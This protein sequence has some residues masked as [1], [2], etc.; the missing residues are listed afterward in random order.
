MAV[1]PLPSAARAAGTSGGAG[2]V[3]VVVTYRCAEDAVACLASLAAAAPDL[4]VVVVDNASG[5]GT[6][7]RV[8]AWIDASGAGDRVRLIALAENAGFGAGCNRG[9]DRALAERPGLDHVLL[10]NPDCVVG[11]GFLGPLL[12]TAARHPEAGVVGGKILTHD[13]ADVWFEHGEWRPWTLGSAHVPAP[14]AAEEDEV[15]FVTGALMLVDAGLL[16]EGLRF[17]ERFFLYCEDADLCREVVRRGRTLRVNRRSVVRHRGAGSQAGAAKVVGNM[18]ALQLRY[19]TRN[20]VLL[21]RKR[22]TAPQFA[23][24]CLVVWVV[25]PV[26]WML[27]FRT[28]GFLPA[29]FRALVEGF[30]A[31]TDSSP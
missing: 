17:D 20:K 26:S 27:R 6:P 22:L 3:A 25:R 10:V 15:G 31:G 24:F 5:D 16:R 1:T 21:A 8:A 30:G 11:P 23:A 19:I 2:N 13:G 28:V 4:P 14:T 29:Y 7:E 9:I 12:E 18:N